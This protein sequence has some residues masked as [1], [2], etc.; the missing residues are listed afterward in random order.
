[1]NDSINPNPNPSKTT[2][3]GFSRVSHNIIN[4]IIT[5]IQEAGAISLHNIMLQCGPAHSSSQ[6][7][8]DISTFLLR[9]FPVLRYH[10]RQSKVTYFVDGLNPPDDAAFRAF[11]ESYVQEIYPIYILRPNHKH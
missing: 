8:K 9:N 11:F 2:F 5:E 1:M 7:R 3:A 4:G 10:A 6:G